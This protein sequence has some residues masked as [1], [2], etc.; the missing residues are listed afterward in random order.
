M[1]L[2]LVEGPTEKVVS[3]DEAKAHLR[4]T[5]NDDN[6]LIDSIID[7]ATKH[8]ENSTQRAF[9][10]QTWEL[11]LDEF[12]CGWRPTSLRRDVWHQDIVLPLAPLI[13]V[14]SVKY[15]DANGVEQTLSP[16]A[17]RVVGIGD[18][19]RIALVSGQAWPTTHCDWPE[20][21]I[22]RFVAGYDD[23]DSPPV[24]TIPTPIVQ[25][26]KLLVS[27]FYE[28]RE[29]FVRGDVISRLP[30]TV[31]ALLQPYRVFG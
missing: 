30:Q 4:V 5:H 14:E 21:V 12:P 15:R 26:I 13:D 22:V 29:E 20:G 7:A 28:H 3:R 27:Q 10:R 17:Y 1:S 2:Y 23:G 19:G 11:R 18:R 9:K 8:A 24:A 6:D 31:E 25:A 16:A